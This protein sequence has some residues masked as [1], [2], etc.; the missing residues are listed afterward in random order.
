MVALAGAGCQGSKHRTP[1][2]QP[3]LSFFALDREQ[4]RLVSDYEPVSRAL[5]GYERAFR[6]WRA[7]RIPNAAFLRRALAFR[8]VVARSF[9]RVRRAPAT[10]ETGRA[11]ELL[12]SAL[13]ARRLALDAL[14]RLDA[15]QRYWNR[16][17]VDARRALTTLQEIR[18]QARLIPL[19][20]DSVS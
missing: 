14:P 10:G 6:D 8:T 1:E 13:K 9:G 5:T 18:D 2:P 20:E 11:K 12:V 17:V 16:S 3:R 4:Q 7:G 15:Y 19:P